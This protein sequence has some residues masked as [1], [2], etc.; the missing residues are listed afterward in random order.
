MA[1]T[2]PVEPEL[3]CLNFRV[4]YLQ[5]SIVMY[6]QKVS[7]ASILAHGCMHMTDRASLFIVGEHIGPRILG[8]CTR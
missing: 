7:S 2:Y 3:R 5:A 6:M 1:A 4:K 8:T